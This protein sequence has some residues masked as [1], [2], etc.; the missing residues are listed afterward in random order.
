MKKQI[1]KI[2]NHPMKSYYVDYMGNTRGTE[3]EIV[4]NRFEVIGE[5][6]PKGFVLGWA[7]EPKK[8]HPRG[9]YG[10]FKSIPSNLL[11]LGKG[12]EVSRGKAVM[13]KDIKETMEH[14]KKP[15]LDMIERR[16]VSF[17]NDKRK[18]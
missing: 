5:Y 14:I 4:F 11:M 17:I 10:Y 12:Y 13:E 15:G 16:Y 18:I 3:R 8:R 9:I 1:K 6:G 7:Y 2:E